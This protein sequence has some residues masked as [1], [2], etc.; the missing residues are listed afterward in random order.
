MRRIVLFVLLLLAGTNQASGAVLE[1]RVLDYDSNDPV[2]LAT[3]RVE[4]TSQAT[5]SNEEGHYR[6]RL[7]PG[8][9]RIKFSHVS[10]YSEVVEIEAGTEDLTRDVRLHSSVITVPGTKVYDRAYD[11]AQR[12]I[13]EAIARKRDLLGNLQ[14]YQFDAYTRL[15]V[16]R[17]RTDDDTTILVVTET[18]LQAYWKQPDNYKEVILSRRQTANLLPEQNLVTVGRILNF[19]ANRIDLG[20]YSVVSP[21]ATDALDHYNYYLMDTIYVDGQAV[22]RLEV[23]PKN[24]H[25]PLFV[26][27]I[28]IADSSYAV[29]GV[30]VGVTEGV[31]TPLTDDLRYRQ[32]FL[33]F[34]GEYWMPDR[35]HLTADVVIG[36]PFNLSFKI[37]YLAALTN[38]RFEQQIDPIRFDEFEL[39]VAHDADKVDSATWSAAQLVPLTSD[40]E[41]AYHRIDSLQSLPGPIWLT[42]L[43]VLGATMIALLTPDI[44]HFTR[45]EGHYLGLGVQT[46]RLHPRWNLRLKSGY[47]IDGEFWQH[48]YG[49]VH[50]LDVRRRL[51]VGLHWQDQVQ[52]TPT[53]LMDSTTNYTMDALLHKTSPADYYRARGISIHAQS[54]VLRNVDLR[55]SYHDQRHSSLDIA[56]DYSVF[57]VSKNSG[58][59][60][61]N[62]AVDDGRMR[63]FELNAFYDSRPLM[64]D[65]GRLRRIHAVPY[66]RLE[67][68]VEYSHPELANS[69]YDFVRYSIKAFHQRRILSADLTTLYLYGGLADRSLPRQRVFTADHSEGWFSPVEPFKT[70]GSISYKGDRLG[71]WYIRQDFGRSLWRR[72]GLPL[73][74]KI[75]FSLFVYGGSL[76][77][78]FDR[79]PAPDLGYE[80]GVARN[81]FHEIGLGLGRIPPLFFELYFT[82]QLSNHERSNR[83]MFQIGWGALFPNRN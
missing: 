82:W 47:A 2:G 51:R 56:T 68:A 58:Q 30:D 43:K 37:D 76:W 55:L 12:I 74:Q 48:H 83:F 26:G 72:S 77:T 16:R 44:Y 75:P 33:L 66:S 1:G 39:E 67:L 36:F 63:S 31:E 24:P 81:G 79:G 25:S 7:E 6:L 20:P 64:M 46:D 27:T 8:T 38:Y 17:P 45:V 59:P 73:I 14:Q 54:K 70:T 71:A 62:P 22:Y 11:A 15:V 40:I 61:A 80:Y 10:Y 9:Y 41:A 53:L 18:Q 60:R 23:E 5:L 13:L 69:E 19:N 57:A 49:F 21:T 28:D 4:G 65:Q 50:T 3:V 32:R 52:R 42:G 78:E 29:V 35:I 34:D